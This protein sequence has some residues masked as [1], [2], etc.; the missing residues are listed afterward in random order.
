MIRL[1]VAPGTSHLSQELI[2]EIIDHLQVFCLQDDDL[3][4]RNAVFLKTSALISRIFRSRSQKHLFTHIGVYMTGSNM[5]QSKLGRLNNVFSTNPRLASHVRIFT[6]RIRETDDLCSRSFDHP[7]FVACLGHILQSGNTHPSPCGLQIYLTTNDVYGHRSEAIALPW[8]LESRTYFIPSVVTSRLTSIEIRDIL[9]VPIALFDACSNLRKLNIFGIR[10]VPFEESERI[11]IEKRPLIR[12]LLVADSEDLI[13][14]TG[15]RFD[16]LER[17]VFQG[18]LNDMDMDT[19]QHIFN[20]NPSC[21]GY[22]N[23]FLPG[24]YQT[25]CRQI[26]PLTNPSLSLK[27]RR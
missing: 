25:K 15:L 14:R 10:L 21:L 8:R 27:Q 5:A 9:N 20:S 1:S 3:V 13:C 4:E 19:M 18:S 17:L 12:E 2:D 22:L 6:V 7:H 16:A 11:P 26:L 24:T 23:F